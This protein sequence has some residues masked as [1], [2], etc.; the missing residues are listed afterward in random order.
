MSIAAL[1]PRPD[2]RS[3]TV[4]CLHA[5][6]S[7]ARQWAPVVGALP[8]HVR[9]LTPELIGYG[10]APGWPCGA[11][12]SLDDEA[13]AI[14]AL[15][16]PGGVHL[17]GHSYGAAVALQVAL[18]CPDRVRGLTL[19]EPVRFAL[20]SGAA[21]ATRAAG[22][23]IAD[24]AR[25]VGERVAAGDPLAAARIFVD[26][27]SGTGSF[28]ALDERRR[29]A[30]AAH[31]PKV[32]AEFGALFADRTPDAAYARLTM[33][34]RL[35]GGARSPLPALRVSDR[36]ERLLPCAT[37]QVFAD[38]GHMGPVQDPARVAAAFVP[39]GPPQPW[40]LAA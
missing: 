18:R 35:L 40:P 33:P 29:R 13:R 26:Y 9:A 20:L 15:L 31:M 24:L 6:G 8:A 2:V 27:W 17:F 32:D 1:Q 37:R 7:S 38:L 39:P 3:E 4:V 34:V 28:D 11:P 30:I 23:A 19:Y 10:R 22:E 21:A 25:R 12:V 14:E 16:P 36:L 5:S